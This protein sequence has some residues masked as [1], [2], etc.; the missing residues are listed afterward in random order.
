MREGVL[1]QGPLAR[2][3][4]REELHAPGVRGH[5]VGYSLDGIFLEGYSAWR[6][7][8]SSTRTSSATSTLRRCERKG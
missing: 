8:K 7:G 1:A 6:A 5:F 4:H 2:F 3:V